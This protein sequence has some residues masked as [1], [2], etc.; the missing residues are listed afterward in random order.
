MRFEDEAFVVE[1]RDLAERDRIVGF[2]SRHHGRRRGV[3]RAAKAKHSR[4]AGQ[5]QLLAKVHITWWE[6]E[7]RELGRI[8]GIELVRPARRFDSGEL[9]DALLA[10]AI[11]EHVV[12]FAPEG[13]ADDAL[14]RLVDSVLLALDQGADRDLSM[15]Y[16]ETWILRLAGIFPTLRECPS[17]GGP[18][19]P[20]AA[21]SVE[22]D[23]VVCHDCAAAQAP[24]RLDEWSVELLQTIGRRPLAEVMVAPWPAG[25][26]LCAPRFPARG[27]AQLPGDRVDPRP[28]RTP[29]TAALDGRP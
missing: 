17:C 27:V 14:F 22:Q 18:V 28:A 20:G 8:D 12:A 19:G 6:S 1:V 25:S 9:E 24:L 11:A 5:L 13:E 10:F 3:A 15:A 2:L 26:R 16:L 23:A 29:L 4:F 7:G 21:L